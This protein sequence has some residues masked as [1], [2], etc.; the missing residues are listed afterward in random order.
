VVRAASW[1]DAA[2]R[3][4]PP[5]ARHVR[6]A[7]AAMRALLATLGPAASPERACACAEQALADLPP[8]DVPFRGVASV[9]YGQAAFAQG[10][11]AE[12][13]RILTVAAADGRA[14]GLVHGAL[15]VAGH[16]VGVQR[17]RGARRRA[18]ATGRAALAWAGER[19]QAATGRGA[20]SVLVADPT[21]SPPFEGYGAVARPAILPSREVSRGT[22]SA[23]APTSTRRG[24]RGSRA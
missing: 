17:L 13:E 10:R 5:D 22:A 2:A 3:A 4:V 24:R 18:L 21:P 19:G 14:A 20:L 8:T 15:L 23:S 6:G 12:A 9:A 11:P 7:V 1:T 16:Q